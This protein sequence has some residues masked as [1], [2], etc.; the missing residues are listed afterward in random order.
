[1]RIVDHDEDELMN[2]RDMSLIAWKDQPKVF[3]TEQEQEEDE[4]DA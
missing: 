2:H 4:E 3:S 1:M